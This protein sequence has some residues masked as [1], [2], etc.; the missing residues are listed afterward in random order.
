MNLIDVLVWAILMAFIIKGF[1]KGLVREVCSLL[2][3]VM[4]IWAACKYYPPLSAA[5][6][7]FIHLPQNV[8]STISFALI[9]LSIGL[10]FF[11]LGHLL[12]IVFKI[13][14]LGGV[15]RVGGVVFGFLQ[16]A[17]V[18]SVLLYFGTS[19]AMPAK[20][21]HS[22]QESKS[23]RPFIACGREI[24]SGWDGSAGKSASR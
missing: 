9:F 12:T 17:L 13:A 4:G 24:V 19:R 1:L 14:L 23:S 21:K 22:L 16:G 5:I 3:L 7:P 6:R 8:S 20:L 10:L 11:F 15:N 2:G 18:L